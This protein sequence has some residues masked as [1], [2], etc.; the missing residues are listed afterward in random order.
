MADVTEFRSSTLTDYSSQSVTELVE[1]ANDELDSVLN[2][3]KLRPISDGY[4]RQPV[5][6]LDIGVLSCR[7]ILFDGTAGPVFLSTRFR[8][9]EGEPT[10]GFSLNP[11][12]GGH[13]RAVHYFAEEG[14]ARP[15]VTPFAIGSNKE[16]VIDVAGL[17]MAS[18]AVLARIMAA[19]TEAAIRE[20]FMAF[21]RFR[22]PRDAS[23]A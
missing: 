12:T 15:E 21:N 20:S 17:V 8:P 19:D 16:G 14:L 3:V 5:S 7:V 1:A 10:A 2:I 6:W 9:G 18:T 11:R 23:T 22:L 13:S 4:Q